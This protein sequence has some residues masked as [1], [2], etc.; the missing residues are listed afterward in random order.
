MI[1]GATCFSLGLRST[2]P[3]GAAV[4]RS[5]PIDDGI[6]PRC[7]WLSPVL[8]PLSGIF[9]DLD[10][11]VRESEGGLGPAA[12]SELSCHCYC[13]CVKG[14]GR[15]QSASRLS[16]LLPTSERPIGVVRCSS[17]ED[18]KRTESDVEATLCGASV[19]CA[20]C[21]HQGRCNSSSAGIAS[22]RRKALPSWKLGRVCM[23]DLWRTALI[24][25][26]AE[27]GD[28]PC[29]PLCFCLMRIREGD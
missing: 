17:A 8:P 15:T 18:A 26:L 25:V 10:K 22:S 3:T 4:R 12:L 11:V 19:S 5:C 16:F 2:P 28:S 23:A 21:S 6:S 14:V 9:L 20:L 13:C 7:R 1:L 24:A 27:E 29:V